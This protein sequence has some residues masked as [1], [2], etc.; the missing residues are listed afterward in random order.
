LT[1]SRR[2]DSA[3]SRRISLL[4]ILE[5]FACMRTVVFIGIPPPTCRPDV[6]KRPSSVACVLDYFP[7]FVGP[8]TL[9]RLAPIGPHSHLRGRLTPVHCQ[10]IVLARLLHPVQVL[11][12]ARFG[13]SRLPDPEAR[14]R[15][16]ETSSLPRHCECNVDLAGARHTSGIH[17]L[18]R[19][20][21]AFRVHLLP[22]SA[23]STLHAVGRSG[24]QHMDAAQ[25]VPP[26]FGCFG[27]PTS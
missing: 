17:S 19:R 12:L 21:T 10:P 1:M 20:N 25:P 7:V 27:P 2:R 14:I 11:P 9:S 16:L 13:K 5:P 15:I 24:L 3:R 18:Q 26:S 8:A 4:L 22:C 23:A 6:C